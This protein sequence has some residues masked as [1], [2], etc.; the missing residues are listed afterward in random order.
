MAPRELAVM[1][2]LKIAFSSGRVLR[3]SHTVW[4]LRC[5]KAFSPVRT[6]CS[7]W[8]QELCGNLGDEA[9]SGGV[10]CR[11]FEDLD[12]VDESDTC[13]NLGQVIC[14]FQP[15]PGFRCG[16]DQLDHH[17]PGGGY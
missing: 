5:R 15:S 7:R 8:P 2:R 16:Q 4:P 9:R 12:A 10:V 3:Y 11:R 1:A 14:A 17:H 6:L 13:D